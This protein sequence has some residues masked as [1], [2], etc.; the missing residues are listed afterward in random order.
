MLF[1]HH[2]TKKNTFRMEERPKIIPTSTRLVVISDVSSKYS[3]IQAACDQ[4]GY[5]Y[6]L[7]WKSNKRY[8]F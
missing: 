6:L 5:E 7:Q 4:H 3:H 1:Y 8:I 2:Y